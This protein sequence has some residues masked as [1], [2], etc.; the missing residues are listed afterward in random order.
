MREFIVR[1]EVFLVS[2]ESS[3]TSRSTALRQPNEML[4][5]T[6]GSVSLCFQLDARD[7]VAFLA[8]EESLPYGCVA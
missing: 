7:V 5:Y 1:L 6:L 8:G 2:C 3:S 4:K